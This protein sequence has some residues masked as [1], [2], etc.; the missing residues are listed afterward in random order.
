MKEIQ[1]HHLLR[2]PRQEKSQNEH[3][4]HGGEDPG[5]VKKRGP[6]RLWAAR[7]LTRTRASLE[8]CSRTLH[9]NVIGG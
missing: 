9:L 6:A 4:A 2:K 7:R 3:A 5:T 1:V 8:N